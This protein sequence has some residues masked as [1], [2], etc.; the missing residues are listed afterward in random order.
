MRSLDNFH[1]ESFY[2][3]D[4]LRSEAFYDVFRPHSENEEFDF[5]R[6]IFVFEECLKKIGKES[7]TIAPPWGE[8]SAETIEAASAALHDKDKPWL[9][10]DESLE[11]EV[12]D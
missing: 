2:E 10:T 5:V 9:C 4:A 6:D 12:E 11:A 7:V 1:S 3:R 8:C